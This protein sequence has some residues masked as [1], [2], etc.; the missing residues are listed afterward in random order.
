MVPHKIPLLLSYDD[1]TLSCEK[2]RT[3]LRNML[4]LG[5]TLALK[6]GLSALE[7]LHFAAALSGQAWVPD[8]ALQALHQMGLR[9]R[10]HLPLQVLS[11][12]QKRR[13]ALARLGLSPARLWRWRSLPLKNRQALNRCFPRRVAPRMHALS[14]ITAL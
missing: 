10:E 12:G 4:Y 5:H 13:V 2:P 11:Q 3:L 14:K 1:Q 6:E 7:N 8:A 9:G